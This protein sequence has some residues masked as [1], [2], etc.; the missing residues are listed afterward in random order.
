MPPTIVKGFAADNNFDG[1]RRITGL[2]SEIGPV[3]LEDGSMVDGG[4]VLMRELS[5]LY[6]FG[7]AAAA[8]RCPS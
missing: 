7:E 1:D 6:T 5:I 8:R 2:G 4:R 3:K